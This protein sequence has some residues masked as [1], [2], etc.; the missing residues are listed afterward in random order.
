MFSSVLPLPLSVSVS[1]GG[2]A[3]YSLPSHTDSRQGSGSPD[4]LLE[5]PGPVPGP[6]VE[7]YPVDPLSRGMVDRLHHT[8]GQDTQS[9]GSDNTSHSQSDSSQASKTDS[10]LTNAQI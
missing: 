10:N 7:F 8:W 4:L 3:P 1:G 9:Q 2:G 5:P 6:H